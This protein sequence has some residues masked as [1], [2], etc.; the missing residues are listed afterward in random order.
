MPNQTN[1]SWTGLL[2][3]VR[4][5]QVSSGGSGSSGV[6]MAATKIT[7]DGL[8]TAD[9]EDTASQALVTQVVALGVCY[10]GTGHVQTS[11]GTT[12]DGGTLNDILIDAYREVQG[13]L[14]GGIVNATRVEFD[15]ASTFPC[16]VCMRSR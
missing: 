9:R 11:A 15:C 1:N 13:W 3:D 10:L 5:S 2:V 6:R 7:P 8:G 16:S 12:F 4:G 14:V